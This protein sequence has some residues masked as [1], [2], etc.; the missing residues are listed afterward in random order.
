[1]ARLSTVLNGTLDPQQA[2]DLVSRTF[3]ELTN[4]DGNAVF[5][6]LDDAAHT[7]A[8]ARSTGF[9]AALRNEPPLPIS[10]GHDSVTTDSFI[11]QNAAIDMRAEPIR[12]I[13]AEANF[14][15]WLELPLAMAGS[16]E[17]F[18]ALVAYYKEPHLFPSD[19]IEPLRIFADHAASTIR[20][21]QIHRRT[22]QTLDQRVAQL[23]ALAAIN[24]ELTSTLDPQN[25]FV[26]VLD[27]ALDGTTSVGGALLLRPEA[28][29]GTT[30]DDEP[31]MPR[32]VAQRGQD[33]RKTDDFLSRLTI[34]QALETN[35]PVIDRSHLPELSVPIS[36]GADVLGVITL[37]AVEKDAFSPDDVLFVRYL[38]TQAVIAA[39]NARLFK[40]IEDSLNR[41]QIILDSMHEGVILIDAT[42][43]LL[44]ANRQIDYMFNLVPSR[45]MGRS[46]EAL[47]ADTTLNLAEVL[48]FE[49]KALL[50]LIQ[51]MQESHWLGGSSRQSYRI[52]VPMVRFIDR[53]IVST[54][55]NNGLVSGMLLVFADATEDRELAQ[56]REDLTRMIV[57]DLRAPLT[58]VTTSMQLLT[59]ISSEDARL[60]RALSRTVDASQRA[61]RKLLHLVDSLLDI[62]KMESG[63]MTLERVPHL[64]APVVQSVK[65]ELAPLAD[66]L[67]VEIEITVPD[68]ISP[69]VIDAPKIE[70]VLLNLVDNALKFSPVGAQVR[71]TAYVSDQPDF[72]RIDVA[73]RG[74]GIQ[75]VYK[76]RIFDRF[77]QINGI[78]GRRRGTGLGL[79]FC[80]LAVEAHGGR[81]WIEDNPEGG[82]VFAF[83]LPLTN[84][85]VA[86][87]IVPQASLPVA[88]V[89]SAVSAPTDRLGK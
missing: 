71:I 33:I 23:L 70:R 18:G 56:A 1:M 16:T 5:I 76:Q 6:Q 60:Q 58:A 66:D 29:Q 52:D 69:T 73:D 24:Q 48:G 27:Y 15:S 50:N 81:I 31:T 44:L 7:L 40:R 9:P 20:N 88:A 83:T 26:R 37:Y 13:L 28:G 17:C 30:D 61:L 14:V 4:A 43:T 53:T 21:S 57:H 46:I 35:Q 79:T 86:A 3:A 8:L 38:A 75:D 36:R 47:L 11:I 19:E 51:Q 62:A 85:P 55:D 59:D 54:H 42:G 10:L 25:L 41:L 22:S 68:A 65:L 74:P 2:L 87:D 49:P 67:E 32:I 39:D 82:S 77:E 84:K 72:V 63:T 78:Q 64:L 34:A 12:A 89:P 45:I 80:K